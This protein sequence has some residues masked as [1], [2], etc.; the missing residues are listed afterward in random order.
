MNAD[1]SQKMT[2]L[3]RQATVSLVAVY[4]HAHVRAFHD[5]DLEADIRTSAIIC[6]F[7][8][9]PMHILMSGYQCPVRYSQCLSCMLNSWKMLPS[10]L[11]GLAIGAYGLTQA[12]FQVPLGMLSDRVGRK[13]VIAGGLLMFAVGSVIAAVS[14]SIY[15]VIAGRALQGSGAIAA[16]VMA[17]AA[18]LTREEQRTKVMAA[19]GLSIGTSFSLALAVGPI[20]RYRER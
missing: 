13:P 20:L 15:G 1:F 9:K 3:E 14:H 19:I 17:L 5:I 4:A 6:L 10:V 7:Y 18:D 12:L 8:R 16:A 11:I 2:P